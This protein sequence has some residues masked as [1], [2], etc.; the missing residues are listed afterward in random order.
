MH[1]RL[2]DS[3]YGEAMLLAEEARA[4]FG[5]DGRVQREVLIAWLLTQ[6]AVEAGEITP[7]DALHPS[8]RLGDV[9]S[10]VEETIAWLP[11]GARTLVVA[12]VALHRRTAAHDAARAA[13][14]A[15]DS[16]VRAMQDRLAATF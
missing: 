7:G 13:A 8:R 3:L 10:S 6:R 15:V 5:Q 12:S 2:I 9:S 16:P 14:A 1:R 11:V 4:Y